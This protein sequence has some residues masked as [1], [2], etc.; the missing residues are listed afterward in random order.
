MDKKI[1]KEIN[2]GNMPKATFRG[3]KPSGKSV[4]E[5]IAD[6]ASKMKK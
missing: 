4:K 3:N 2:K 6:I 5:K 1:L